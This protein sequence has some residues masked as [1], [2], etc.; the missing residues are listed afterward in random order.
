LLVVSYERIDA[1][2]IISDISV[3]AYNF[4]YFSLFYL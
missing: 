2:N 4:C 1:A 3:T